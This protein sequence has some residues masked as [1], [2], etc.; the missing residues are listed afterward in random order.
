MKIQM[1]RTERMLAACLSQYQ[2][3]SVDE[4]NDLISLMRPK[5][6]SIGQ[7]LANQVPDSK[8]I[9]IA[10]FAEQIK[11]WADNSKKIKN[12]ENN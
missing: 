4:K 5:Y 8:S 9:V 7:I 6:R 1:N 10:K 3:L 2:S 12:K 11:K